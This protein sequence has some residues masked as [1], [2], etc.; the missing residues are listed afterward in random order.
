MNGLDTPMDV[1]IW[2]A[3]GHSKVLAECLSHASRRIVALFD[4]DPRAVST[5]AGVPIS[6][7]VEGFRQWRDAHP[8]PT[9]FLVAIG[10]DR[11]SARVAIHE[12]LRRQGLLPVTVTH[13]TAFV[14]RDAVL[15]ESCQV[16]ARAA[17]CVGARLGFE[18]IVNT[19]AS[20]DHE[21][22]LGKGVHIAPGATLAGCV[23]VGDF[24]MIG[25]GS[26]ILPRRSIGAYTTVGAG[27]VVTR[28]LPERVVAWGNPARVRR[29]AN[30]DS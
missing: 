22:T 24:A 25:A 19:A 15:G 13:P 29:G 11:G 27:S 8:E 12:F 4:N 30:L 28:D 9:G 26:V 17:V 3:A 2:G 10:G 6:I 23:T 20:V 1:V 16:L 18:T 5:L 14:A 21:C 7:G